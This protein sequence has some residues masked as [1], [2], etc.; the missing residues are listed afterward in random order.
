[1]TDQL[2]A[3]A[4][5]YHDFRQSVRPTTAH[6]E[7]DY[8]FAERFEDGSRAGQDREISEERDFARRASAIPEEGLD[9]QDRITREMI[10]W[11]AT[12]R[13][14][15]LLSRM[16]E[17]GADPINGPQALLPVAV[18]KLSLPSPEVAEAMIPKFHAVAELYREMAARH[19]E[20]VAG[21]RT[22]ARF[23]VAETVAQLDA[24]LAT[25]TARDPLL[26]VGETVGID[27]DA[28]LARLR[29]VVESDIR[30]A[31]AAYRDVL[32]D[33]VLPKAR[34]DEQCGLT[35]VPGGAEAYERAIRL[36][37]TLPLTAQ[38]I[39]D[40]GREQI[41]SLADEYR[42]L[43]PEVT[44]SSDLDTI[45]E[46]LRSDPALHHDSAADIVAASKAALARAKA[47]MPG[48]FGILPQA[49]CDVEATTSGALAYYFAPAA[50]GSRGG[51]FFMNTSV[52]SNWGRYQIEATAYHEGIPGHHL[53][54]AIASEL[55]GVPEFRKRAF[56]AAYGE[57]WGLYTE[58]LADEM[59]LYST[60]LDRVGM[61]C[62]DSMR[63]SRLVVDT[64][65][66]ALGWSRQ[67]AIDY[68]VQNSPMREG[69]V[70]AE[71][72]RYA[73]SPG[74]AL[75]YMI[76]RLEIQRIRAEAEAALGDRFE[77]KDF[78][79]TVLG[80]G[81]MPLPTLDRLVKAWVASHRVATPA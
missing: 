23:A 28:W 1:M 4:V 75:A 81:L 3:L 2:S 61:L 33:E 27:R 52:P 19:R 38:R 53:Q 24:L 77:I 71:I 41:A 70:R 80:S 47:A 74:Q 78:H 76:G 32:R 12:V 55:Q 46:A 59:G 56:I 21:G 29:G 58:R 45:L 10:D 63:A 44:G 68:M 48:W 34:P 73:T 26:D 11:D 65:M 14:D 40:I 20:G 18:A 43:G 54:L 50:D 62:A 35:W 8:R 37:T 57:G 51:V 9:A 15:F 67:K 6:L 36:Y 39:H 22:P 7:G 79:D 5:E 25:P 60:P 13:A 42:A 72:D 64:G 31:M 17:F 49:D 30:P 66:H 16:D 69:Q